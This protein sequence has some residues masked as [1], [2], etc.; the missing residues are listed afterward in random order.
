MTQ[1]KGQK[2]ETTDKEA[3]STEGN[4]AF[5]LASWDLFYLTEEGFEAHLKLQGDSGVKVLD[6]ARAAIKKLAEQGAKPR[7]HRGFSRNENKSDEPEIDKDT[8]TYLDGSGVRRCA[9]T[10][11]DGSRCDAKVGNL[12]EGKYGPWYPCPNYKEHKGK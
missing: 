3:P 10:A 4:G 1:K 12:R 7:P 11:K 8:M 9:K 5:P 2:A 6:K